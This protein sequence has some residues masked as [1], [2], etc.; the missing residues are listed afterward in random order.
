MERIIDEWIKGDKAFV[1]FRNP[2]ESQVR[3]ISASSEDLQHFSDISDL[4]GNVG[5]VFAPFKPSPEY[6]LWLLPI[7]E[8]HCFTLG[9]EY[10]QVPVA[11]APVPLCGGWCEYPAASYSQTFQI[12]KE[13]FPHIHV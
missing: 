5:Y 7:E 10:D 2:G 12:F 8:P 9:E 6:P 11:P 13:K 4:K 1:L 3:A